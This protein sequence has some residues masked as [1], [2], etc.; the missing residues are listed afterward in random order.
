MAASGGSTDDAFGDERGQTIVGAVDRS[1]ACH[2]TAAHGHDDVFP[3]LCSA[4]IVAEPVLEFADPD[5]NS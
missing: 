4:Q 3:G 2:G 5:F 1:E